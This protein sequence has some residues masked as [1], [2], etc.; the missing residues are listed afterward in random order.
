MYKTDIC[1]KCLCVEVCEIVGNYPVD[2]CDYFKNKTDFVEVVRCK[3]CKYCTKA[4]SIEN[5]YFCV[6]GTNA[7]DTELDN[8]CS[9]GERK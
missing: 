8:F 7:F 4:V 2:E 3:D 9:Y 1:N 6:V 5:T